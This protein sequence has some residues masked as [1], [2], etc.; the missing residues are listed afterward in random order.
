MP[1]THILLE[2]N[3]YPTT[4]K[5]TQQPAEEWTTSLPALLTRVHDES[6]GA[7]RTR[8]PVSTIPY[9]SAYG[10]EHVQT[11]W[12][13]LQEFVDLAQSDSDS[14]S[15][16]EPTAAD[17]HGNTN[18]SHRSSNSTSSS[19]SSSGS[20]SNNSSSAGPESPRQRSSDWS[21]PL[22]IFDD[23]LHDRSPLL[24]RALR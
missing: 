16:S 21:P 2:H 20:S 24:D 4:Q 13:T 10:G 8:F 1:P 3:H 22:Y 15:E 17:D 5:T 11:R 7:K 9:G 18:S 6:V 12:L 14:K 19:N 23:R